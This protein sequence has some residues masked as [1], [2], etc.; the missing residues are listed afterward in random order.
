M[1][2]CVC[3]CVCDVIAHVCVCVCVCVCVY[4]PHGMGCQGCPVGPAAASHWR[5]RSSRRIP[6]WPGASSVAPARTIP[7]PACP[8]LWP[9]APPPRPRPPATP[10]GPSPTATAAGLLW[11]QRQF[12]GKGNK[13]AG[14]AGAE[15]G[16]YVVPVQPRS[17]WQPIP[18]AA[19]RGLPAARSQRSPSVPRPPASCSPPCLTA[20]A[21][22]IWSASCFF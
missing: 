8:R 9:S 20:G 2:V 17:P 11:Q 18:A 12:D 5:S 3:V 10:Y 6:G 16:G 13:A 22:E 14:W 1:C 15:A 4:R 7:P 21:R 19:W